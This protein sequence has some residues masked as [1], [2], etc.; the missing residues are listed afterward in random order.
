[1]ADWGGV[2]TGAGKKREEK[3][4]AG[5]DLTSMPRPAHASETF[6]SRSARLARNPLRK[7]TNTTDARVADR[8]QLEAL[9]AARL[10][11]FWKASNEAAKM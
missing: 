1:M 7:L 5:W 8:S 10:E 3:P 9:F 2:R 4:C 11:I 6:S